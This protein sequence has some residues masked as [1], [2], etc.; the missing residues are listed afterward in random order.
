MSHMSPVKFKKK[1]PQCFKLCPEISHSIVPRLNS[2]ICIHSFPFISWAEA[3]NESTK[4]W[5]NAV[6]SS[7]CQYEIPDKPSFCS[8]EEPSGT[9]STAAPRSWRRTPDSRLEK[10]HTHTH[11]QHVK[12]LS[13][14]EHRGCFFWF[15]THPLK[16][17]FLDSKRLKMGTI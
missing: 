7:P 5:M 11:T 9:R 16:C 3:L 1:S 14:R 17:T 15:K 2:M 12:R 8:R 4:A 10:D 13:V 6:F